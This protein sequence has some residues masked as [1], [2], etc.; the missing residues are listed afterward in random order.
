[1]IENQK[2]VA[3]WALAT[4]GPTSDLIAGV[5]ANQEMAELIMALARDD[6]P[7]AAFEIADVVICLY[8]LAENLGI[9]INAEVNRKMAINRKRTWKVDP[10]GCGYHR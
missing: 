2:S 1:M 6:L 9:D 3:L 10:F 5:R 7:S 8:R 4:F